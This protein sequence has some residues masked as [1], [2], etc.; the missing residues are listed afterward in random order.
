MHDILFLEASAK[1]NIKIDEVYWFL[2][3]FIF[4]INIDFLL[5]CK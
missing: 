5:D 4:P 3:L 1:S 2:F